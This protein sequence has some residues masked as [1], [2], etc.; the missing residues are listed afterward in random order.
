MG[1]G[2]ITLNDLIRLLGA[3]RFDKVFRSSEKQI[4]IMS[5]SGVIQH[6]TTSTA[7]DGTP[8]APLKHNRP[9]GG[10]QPLRDHGLLQASIS[11]TVTQEGIELA[12]NSP[13]APLHQYGGTIKPKAGRFLAIPVTAEAK[14]VGAP[15]KNRFPRFLFFVAAHSATNT[16]LLCERGSDGKLIVQYVLKT[17][18]TVA[19]RPFLGW[20]EATLRKITQLL[21]DKSIAQ[22]TKAFGIR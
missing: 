5:R 21:A 15:R 7:P 2:T 3:E 17:S 19:A 9:N 4:A 11:A 10:N 18:V 8:W 12:A 14:R 22:L 6:F 20:S 1:G 16:G 13:G